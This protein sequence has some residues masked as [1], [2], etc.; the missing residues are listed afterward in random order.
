VR[1]DRRIDPLTGPAYV[2]KDEPEGVSAVV[3][4]DIDGMAELNSAYGHEVGDVE[5]PQLAG[6]QLRQAVAT[7]DTPDVIDAAP[8]LTVSFGV[9][10][11]TDAED[12]TIGALARAA[13]D[14]MNRDRAVRRRDT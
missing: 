6:E 8:R 5:E 10:T 12:G 4:L 14:A 3:W 2:P 9:A 1:S 13:K 7:A 11:A